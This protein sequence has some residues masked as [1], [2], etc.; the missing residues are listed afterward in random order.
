MEIKKL[1]ENLSVA[2]QLMPSDVASIADQGFKTIICNRPDGEAADQPEFDTIRQQAEG[3]GL[4]VV[5]MPVIAGGPTGQNVDDFSA[6]LDNAQSP[7]L[8]YCRTGTRCTILWA[9]SQGAKGI[10]V[11]DIVSTAASAGYDVSNVAAYIAQSQGS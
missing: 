9:L 4:D 8:A 1:N 2:G 3:A 5:F 11:D 7:I 10:P 6:A